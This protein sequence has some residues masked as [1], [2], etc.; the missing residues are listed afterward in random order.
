MLFIVLHNTT[1][2]DY[3]VVLHHVA[4]TYINTSLYLCIYTCVI[5]FKASPTHSMSFHEARGI[6]ASRS[7]Y[8]W[9][10]SNCTRYWYAH[11]KYMVRG[12]GPWYRGSVSNV[13]MTKSL[14][15]NVKSSKLP[16]SPSNNSFQLMLFCFK[17][18]WKIKLFV[19][20]FVFVKFQC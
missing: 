14:L 20:V 16:M 4:K 7:F 5:I 17:I 19:F 6:V 11:Q 10:F 2:H 8:G 18:R 9:A 12:K 15:S 13:K 1:T 3:C